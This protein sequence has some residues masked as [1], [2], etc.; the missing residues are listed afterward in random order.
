MKAWIVTEYGGPDVLDLREVEMPEPGDDEVRIRIH[1]TTVSS[2]DWRIRGMNIPRG[3][4]TV[5]RLMFGFSAPR[6]PILGSE[7]SGRIDAVGRNVTGF[8]VGDAVFAYSDKDMGCHAE[9][10]VLGADASIAPIPPALSFGEAAAMSFGG[11]T[12]LEFLRRGRIETG[13]RVLINGASGAVGTAA[14]QLSRFFGA[15]VTGVCSSANADL[16]RSLGADEV[17]DYRTTDVSQSGETYDII[18]DTAATLPYARAKHILAVDGT[19]L[20][21]NGDAPSLLSAPFYS[22]STKRR[23]IA[24]PVFGKPEDLEFLADLARD[25][26]YRPVVDSWFD[27]EE[28]P[29]AHRLVDSGRKRGNV[30]VRVMKSDPPPDKL[31]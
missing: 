24:G 16:V 4:K 22:M 10:K 11:C 9:Y 7:L 3:F 26:D 1:A 5:S 20:V 27:F 8:A 12:A 15:H 19:L 29:E 25:G 28:L 17:V 31:D 14:V 30:V 23:V 13:H 6:S 2:G 21:V 18:M